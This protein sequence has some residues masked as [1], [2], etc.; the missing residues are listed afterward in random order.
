MP[1]RREAASLTT[2]TLTGA[3]WMVVWRMST[4]LL[5]IINTIVLARILSPADFG[6]VVLATTFS[7]AVET[8]SFFGI[9]DAIIREREVDK[10]LYDT[11]FTMNIIR[12]LIISPV[13]AACATPIAV[14]FNEPRLTAILLVLACV[15]LFS[16][17]ENIGILDFR[18][19]LSFDKEFQLSLIPRFVSV[20]VSIGLAFAFASYW[21]LV[22]GIITN[23][24]LR[25]I[26]SYWIHSFRPG[27]SLQSWRRL[28]SFSFW[29]WITSLV[30]LARDRIDT[31]AI[32]RVLGPGDTGI[33]SVG[34]EIGSLTST[35]LVEPLSTALYA[36]L[37][38]GRREGVN[39]ADGYFRA[40]AAT[41]LL[42]LPAGMG[43][44]VL[45][46]PVVVLLFGVQWINAVLLVQIFAIAG[47]LKVIAYFSGM[48]LNVHGL[49]RT[50]FYIAFSALVGRVSLLIPLILSL[51]L[52][53]VAIAAVGG[54]FL[55]ELIY[56]VV[57][58]SYFH[59]KLTELINAIWR[60]V[61]ATGVM[62]V[63]LW[64]A[65]F[66]GGAS[67]IRLISGVVV[68]AIVYFG[69]LTGLWLLCGRPTGAE[70]VVGGIMRGAA[71]RIVSKA[72]YVR[73]IN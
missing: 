65:E 29:S 7:Q 33:Y 17:F 13:L 2:R 67:A 46:H 66:G 1:I 4:R 58:F 21:A 32:G 49:I 68:G 41:F 30:G 35:E 8:L 60:C 36:G 38:V 24:I 54:I 45:A 19:N 39:V 27:L 56:M 71:R 22:G 63:I 34:M 15:L 20:G 37:S 25:V 47:A 69:V 12:I 50:Q 48:L 16:S 42:T 57:C 3:G 28:V 6:L 10:T 72:S 73:P 18:R 44:A 53:G 31:L 40:I 43:L 11:G 23:R 51:G 62:G 61:V 9:S 26:V 70:Q 5:G 64:W 52:R 59:L 55:E 14:F